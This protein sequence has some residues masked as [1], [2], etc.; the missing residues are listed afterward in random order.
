LCAAACRSCHTALILL[1]LMKW[2]IAAIHSR[3]A[4]GLFG[5][6]SPATP[7]AGFGGASFGSPFV[8][9]ATP[10]PFGG[11]AANNSLSRSTSKGRSG[12]KR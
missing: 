8:S 6:A 4:G 9:T 12:K 7:A 2:L 10:A 3:I 1:Q 5:Q 11:A